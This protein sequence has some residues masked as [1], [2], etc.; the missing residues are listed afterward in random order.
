MIDAGL[1]LPFSQLDGVAIA[2]VYLAYMVGY[3]IRGAF[4]FGSN[5]PAVLISAWVLGAQQAVLLAA[6]TATLSQLQLLPQGVRDACWPRVVP[7]V[8]AM[9]LGSLIGVWLLTV[10]HADW[11]LLVL[12]LL[13]AWMVAMDRF[14]LL[15][16]LAHRVDVRSPRLA[17]VLA[18]L[19]STMGAISGGG[20]IYL[21][22][23]Y[24]RLA[25]ASTAEFRASNVMIA[26][27]AML[28][29]IL[30]LSAAGLL[31]LEIMVDSA[32]LMPAVVLATLAG[33]RFYRLAEPA[34]FFAAL[35][36]VLLAAAAMLAVRGLLRLI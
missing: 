4:G 13:V 3:Y 9:G 35:Q 16:R 1:P 33:T 10:L 24:L 20:A 23:P 25:A 27:L 28:T 30:M 14:H 36:W 22:A 19:S 6:F 21:L 5:L 29:R 32:A 15:E 26:G 2:T 8:V 11:L 12:A 18:V 31:T 17:A 34:R 7:V